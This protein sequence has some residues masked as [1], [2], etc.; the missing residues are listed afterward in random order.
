MGVLGLATSGGVHLPGPLFRPSDQSQPGF[1][2]SDA[3]LR[4]CTAS[5]AGGGK[6]SAVRADN[7]PKTPLPQIIKVGIHSTTS[8]SPLPAI[9]PKML[10]TSL[11]PP[12]AT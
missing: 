7:A 8:L 4:R 9:H 3:A 2:D 1:A 12:P 11:S 10:S 6:D 5:T